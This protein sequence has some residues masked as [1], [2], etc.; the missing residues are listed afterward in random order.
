LVQ[1]HIAGAKKILTHHQNYPS[2]KH[3]L[4]QHPI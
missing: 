2:P 4:I 3:V 1:N